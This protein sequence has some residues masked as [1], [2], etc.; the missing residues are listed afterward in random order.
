MVVVC[1]RC[2]DFNAGVIAP[3]FT[4]GTALADEPVVLVSDVTAFRPTRVHR[5]I[6]RPARQV[7]A[8]VC[9]LLLATTAVLAAVRPHAHATV[10]AADPSTV[11]STSTWRSSTATVTRIPDARDTRVIGFHGRLL[12]VSELGTGRVRTLALPTITTAITHAWMLH[13]SVVVAAGESV[14]SIRNLASSHPDVVAFGNVVT[15]EDAARGVFPSSAPDRFWVAA[16]ADLVREIRVDGPVLGSYRLPR[17][18]DTLVGVVEG[19]Q[20]LIQRSAFPNALAIWDPRAGRFVRFIAMDRGAGR[21]SAAGRY[22]LVRDVECVLD[23]TATITDTRTG[24]SRHVP[25]EPGVSYGAARVSFSPDGGSVAIASYRQIAD[26]VVSHLSVVALP[27]L[28]IVWSH[29][30]EAPG[31]VGELTWNT[32][33]RWL[34]FDSSGDLFSHHAGDPGAAPVVWSDDIPNGHFGSIN[35]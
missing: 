4:C 33:G 5:E 27:S 14:Y 24:S 2:G 3:C 28:R 10:T 19:D 17:G 34:F 15:A 29:D 11:S 23:C 31:I 18:W 9:T 8:A 1:P 22:V 20:L 16:T 7:V 30:V 12:R 32:S 26:A 13:A 6:P 35:G 21:V 25:A